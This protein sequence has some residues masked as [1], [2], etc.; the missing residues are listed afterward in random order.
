LGLLESLQLLELAFFLELFPE[1]VELLLFGE[2]VP[3]DVSVRR[4]ERY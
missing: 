3:E 2:L 1:L 4:I